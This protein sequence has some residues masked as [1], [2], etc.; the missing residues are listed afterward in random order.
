MHSLTFLLCQSEIIVVLS[1]AGRLLSVGRRLR[2]RVSYVSAS[3][4]HHFLLCITVPQ[5][6][7]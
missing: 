3:D 5:Q 6:S 7:S 1:T 4:P 2:C